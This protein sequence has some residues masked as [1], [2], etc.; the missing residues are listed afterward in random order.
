MQEIKED[1]KAIRLDVSSI[2][3][4]VA[5]NTVSLNTHIMRTELAEK[6]IEYLERIFMGLTAVAVLGGLIKLLIS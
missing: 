6:R 4:D 1:L 3:V 5:K 2:K